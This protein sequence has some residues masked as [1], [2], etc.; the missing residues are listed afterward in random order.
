MLGDVGI[1]TRVYKSYRPARPG[2]VVA[3]RKAGLSKRHDGGWYD[4]EH[5]EYQVQWPNDKTGPTWEWAG[6]VSLDQ[7]IRDTNHKLDT[8]RKSAAKLD[9]LVLDA[10]KHTNLDFPPIP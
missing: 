5:L 10:I 2:V 6:I 1:G 4:P 3:V 7:L 8:H 9:A